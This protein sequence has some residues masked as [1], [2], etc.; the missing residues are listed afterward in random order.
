MLE[1]EKVA[2]SQ[3]VF[4]WLCLCGKVN[5]STYTRDDVGH[6]RIDNK[7]KTKELKAAEK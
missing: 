5:M 4:T 1:N 2:R 7:K 3:G 6:S